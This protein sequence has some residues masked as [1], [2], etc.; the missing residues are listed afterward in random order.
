MDTMLRGWI[1]IAERTGVR[2]PYTQSTS[3]AAFLQRF[4]LVRRLLE[5]PAMMNPAARQ[6]DIESGIYEMAGH[7][8]SAETG[9][10]SVEDGFIEAWARM[11]GAFAMDR[12][13]GRIHALVYVSSEDVGIAQIS[14]R[15]GIPADVAEMHLTTLVEWGLVY[16]SGSVFA[17]EQDPWAWFLRTVRARQRNELLPIRNAIESVRDAAR[18]LAATSKGPAASKL[19]VTLNRIERFTS[20]VGDFA[21]LVDA[22]VTLGAA[23]M[24]KF[25]SMATRFV[26]RRAA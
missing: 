12:T 5:Q 6:R 7:T 1:A 22:L 21:K 23:P 2:I 19:R 9:L 8:N 4:S 11:A 14:E 10:H 18:Q 25:V 20:F 26:P 15:L 13:M 17:A 16:C 3:S 24:L